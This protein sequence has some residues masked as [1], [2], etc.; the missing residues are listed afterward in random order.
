MLQKRLDELSAK[1]HQT[2]TKATAR[3]GKHKIRKRNAAALLSRIRA[4]HED[5]WLQHYPSEPQPRRAPQFHKY[6]P[7][8]GLVNLGN[9]C[10]VNAVGQALF[11]CDAACH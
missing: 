6:Q 1:S 2:P 9:T 7:Y 3:G 10:Y 8:P 11:H 4:A 5:W